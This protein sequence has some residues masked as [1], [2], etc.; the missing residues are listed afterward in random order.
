LETDRETAVLLALARR[1]FTDL[2]LTFPLV[3]ARGQWTTTWNLKL[4]FPV[5]LRNVLYGLGNVRDTAAEENVSPGEVVPLPVRAGVQ[6]AHLARPDGS[7]S[8][9]ARS[10]QAEFLYKE[11]DRPGIYRAAW[12]GGGR[13]FAVNLL[14]AD[15]SNVQPRD[16]VRIGA[17]EVAAEAPR[18]QT[19]ET[20]KWIALAA[21]AVVFAEWLFYHR[22][23]GA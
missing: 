7:E 21:L 6:Q 8:T 14:D 9:V 20:W 16:E 15:E 10:G 13:T 12:D 11:T 1:S 19:R 3:N 4:S 22:R 2:V 5:F 18:G 17:Q 23:F